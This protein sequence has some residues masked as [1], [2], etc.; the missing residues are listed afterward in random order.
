MNDLATFIVINVDRDKKIPRELV[1]TL[2]RNGWMMVKENSIFVLAWEKILAE[3]GQNARALLTRIEDV[4]M[5]LRQLRVK[6]EIRTLKAQDTP[7]ELGA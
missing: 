3:N 2:K 5:T 1:E 7:E 4:R 6:Y